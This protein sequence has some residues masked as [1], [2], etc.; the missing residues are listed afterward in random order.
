MGLLGTDWL[1]LTAP[2]LL[3]ASCACSLGLYKTI[4]CQGGADTPSRYPSLI[5][6]LFFP[7]SNC[8]ILLCIQVFPTH[9]FCP[10]LASDLLPV[11]SMEHTVI[12]SE[13]ATADICMLSNS[14]SANCYA[15]EQTVEQGPL[16][17]QFSH[18]SGNALMEKLGAQRVNFSNLQQTFEGA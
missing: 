4:A 18:I 1:L 7:T 12:P 14:K 2:L 10:F 15:G 11:N 13:D 16:Q 8:L 6:H 9:R 3:A 5:L 17:A